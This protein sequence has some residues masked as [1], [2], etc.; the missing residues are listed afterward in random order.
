M[1][2]SH[3]SGS[4]PRRRRPSDRQLAI[5]AAVLGLVLLAATAVSDFLIGSF[6]RGHSMLTSLVANITV[7]LFSAA[8]FGQ[9]L[10]QR[11]RSKWNLLAQSVMAGLAQ[12]ARV[13]WSSLFSLAQLGGDGDEDEVFGT[14]ENLAIASD[15]HQ[16]RTA[17][18][19]VMADPE[20]R[21]RLQV[22]VTRLSEH[23][24]N[25]ITNW[26]GLL[27]GAA[28]YAHVLEGHVELGSRL[29]WLSAV[30]SH[31]EPP[32]DQDQRRR[33]LSRASIAA[34]TF[35]DVDDE[36]LID[37]ATCITVLAAQLDHESLEMAIN[38]NPPN[39]WAERT[40]Q[41][42]QRPWKTAAQLS[43]PLPY[44]SLRSRTPGSVKK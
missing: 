17:M 6:W 25:V 38:V 12:T 44:Q 27:V 16:V 4:G 15:P 42:L 43:S 26:A 20:R 41:L 13:T 37:Q 5:A 28:P 9:W 30:M 40:N 29:Q 34:A 10:E 32:P 33:R 23:T 7:V 11:N 1:T 3:P 14:P 39:W 18:Q 36:W 21:A 19:A 22:R 35:S 31:R 24:A 2:T 8:V